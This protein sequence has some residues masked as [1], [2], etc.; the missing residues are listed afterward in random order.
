MAKSFGP[1]DGVNVGQIFK[2]REEIREAWLHMPLQQGISGSAGEGADSIVLSGGY[3]D[4]EFNDDSILYT[5]SGKRDPRT[6]ALLQDQELVG[7]N[8]ALAKSCDDGLPV[9]VIQALGIRKKQLPT[10]GYRY[11]GVYFI[12]NYSRVRGIDG[13]KIWQFRLIKQS[14][15]ESAV[16]DS[17][18]NRR[19]T[20]S[21]QR[22]VRNTAMSS[23]LK[24]KYEYKCQ[25]CSLRI[26]TPAGFYSEG[27]HIRPLGTNHNGADLESNLLCLCPNHHTMLDYGAIYIDDDLHVFERDGDNKIGKLHLLSDHLIDKNNI[28]YQRSIF[29]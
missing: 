8:K 18:T 28:A 21:V 3:P 13:Y 16:Y 11:E 6:G 5:G 7:V 29:G 27:A 24:A 14:L 15:A 19:V 23:A 2:T 20:T 1:A 26:E 17:S 9:R 25:I 10:R 4:D 12:E 22:L